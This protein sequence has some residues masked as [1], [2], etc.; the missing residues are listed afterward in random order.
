MQAPI[1]NKIIKIYNHK[2]LKQIAR[3]IIKVNDKKLVQEIAK[4]WI[5]HTFFLMKNLRKQVSKL[6]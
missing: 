2:T 5:I 3:E 1:K 6:I 4:N